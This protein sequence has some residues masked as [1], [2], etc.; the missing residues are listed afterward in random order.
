MTDKNFVPHANELAQELRAH[1]VRVA[2]D[3]GD[4]KLAD[5]IKTASK[6][7]IPCLIVVGEN[8][9]TSDEFVVRN[10]TSGAETKL[11][12][13]ELANFFTESL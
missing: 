12:R 8:E 5:Q 7:R 1:G 13:A 4:K 6:H 9:T 3:F 11:A 10:L 2:I